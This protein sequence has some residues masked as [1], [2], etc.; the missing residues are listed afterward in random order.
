MSEAQTEPCTTESC[1]PKSCT[2]ETAEIPVPATDGAPVGF[3]MTMLVAFMAKQ[4]VTELEITPED[5]Q[6]VSHSQIEAGDR[7]EGG[8]KLTVTK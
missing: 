8:F 4:G 7:P 2:S 6:I 1:T 5:L 3:W